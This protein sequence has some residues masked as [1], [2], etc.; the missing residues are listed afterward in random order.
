[1]K[2]NISTNGNN[3]YI[4]AQTQQHTP[5][6]MNKMYPA[7]GLNCANNVSNAN[8]V[9][10]NTNNNSKI[11]HQQHNPQQHMVNTPTYC[12]IPS[13]NFN[14]SRYLNNVS[15]MSSMNNI[16]PNCTGSPDPFKGSN[17]HGI[18][19]HFYTRVQDN[20]KN[21]KPNEGRKP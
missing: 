9:S 15:N 20:T 2:L 6:Q 11:S 3:Q 18:P 21:A 19:L 4:Q 8:I 12:S 5:I 17:S 13:T 1:M 7:Q 16:V 10:N 14:N